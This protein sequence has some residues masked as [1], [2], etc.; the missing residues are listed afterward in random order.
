MEYQCQ[1][2]YKFY[3]TKSFSNAFLSAEK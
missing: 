1:Y 2:K 3:M